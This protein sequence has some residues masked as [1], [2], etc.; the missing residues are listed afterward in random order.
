M[1]AE[2]QAL[3]DVPGPPSALLIRSDGSRPE[4]SHPFSADN[5]SGRRSF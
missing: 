2:P 1:D 3:P 5:A 4:R